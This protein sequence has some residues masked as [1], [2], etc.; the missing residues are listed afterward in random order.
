LKDDPVLARELA[1]AF[2][3]ARKALV[4]GERML[5]EEGLE[6][7][8]QSLQDQG[9]V[10]REGVLEQVATGDLDAA[11]G[12]ERLDAMRSARR[13]AYH[14]WRITHHL[15]RC[16]GHDAP[17]EALRLTPVPPHAEAEPP[18]PS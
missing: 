13:V 4:H 7:P 9:R 15:N 14:A 12:I 17:E 10:Y 2:N 8:W 5:G 1:P 6:D 16:R 18:E 11:D 3:D